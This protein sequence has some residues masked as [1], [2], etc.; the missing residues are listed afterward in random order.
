M[1]ADD[2]PLS[3]SLED[4]QKHEYWSSITGEQLKVFCQTQAKYIPNI[5]TSTMGGKYHWDSAVIDGWK[6]QQ[7]KYTGHC[8]I[9]DPDDKRCAWGPSDQ[10]LSLI[11]SYLTEQQRLSQVTS[12][13][14]GIVFSGGGMKGPF[15]IGVW[16]Y[17]HETGLDTKITGVSGS[18]VGAL[19]S[20]LF[21]QGDYEL[22]ERVWLNLTQMDMVQ[23]N[24]KAVLAILQILANTSIPSLAGVINPL[25]RKAAMHSIAPSTLMAGTAMSTLVST[26]S[27]APNPFVLLG[28]LGLSTYSIYNIYQ[29]M[30]RLSLFS[31]DK[32]IHIIK[33]NVQWN[34]I[35]LSPCLVYSTVSAKTYPHNNKGKKSHPL[36]SSFSQAEY[37]CW[38]GYSEDSSKNIRN[39]Q[40]IEDAVLTSA[41][42]PLAYSSHRFAGKDCID[43]GVQDNIPMRP[44]INAGFRNIIVV[45]LLRKDNPASKRELDDAGKGI[46]KEKL[47]EIHFYPVYPDEDFDDG[48]YAIGRRPWHKKVMDFPK[49][50]V[51][52]L[53]SLCKVDRAETERR[54]KQ[55]YCA[56]KKQLSGL[57]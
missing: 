25:A 28:G 36:L 42:L 29:K 8:R 56:A 39:R 1:S 57:I 22:A 17:L 11:E 38:P 9:L 35:L 23:P 7:N 10:V 13:Q 4:L 16:K 47:S 14:Y 6:I 2:K 55:G 48:G 51:N 27:L 37:F 46:P 5:E 40:M 52:K 3:I 19:N 26:T 43:G 33:E 18:S 54:I 44:L 24:A 41:A 30:E 21:T 12:R 20:L 31:Q 53:N 34:K 15:E 45:H 50:I 49:D 32:I